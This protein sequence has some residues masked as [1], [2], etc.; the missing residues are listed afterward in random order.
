MGNGL[1]KPGGKPT[2][3]CGVD[4]F[5]RKIL[6]SYTK[7]C[8]NS[9]D[10][11]PKPVKK[12]IKHK[13]KTKPTISYPVPAD[14]DRLEGDKWRY[15]ILTRL[16][17][18]KPTRPP[19]RQRCRRADSV[20]SSTRSRRS[21]G[22]RRRYQQLQQQ[23][24]QQ[25]QSRILVGPQDDRDRLDPGRSWFCCDQWMD[26]VFNKGQ[27]GRLALTWTH[28]AAGGEVKPPYKRQKPNRRKRTATYV[29]MWL[30]IQQRQRLPEAAKNGLLRSLDRI[31]AMADNM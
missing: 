22:R 3:S 30:R 13:K 6:S 25:Q 29:K 8:T 21:S 28:S 26:V 14:P 23:L 12:G 18:D 16:D 24:Q 15:V 5:Y 27:P 7:Q 11:R 19:R 2:T 20:R 1:G 9:S 10:K 31:N 17:T 4:G